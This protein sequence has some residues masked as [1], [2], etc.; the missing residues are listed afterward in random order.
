MG[1]LIVMTQATL[2]TKYLVDIFAT[3]ILL[4]VHIIELPTLTYLCFDSL[5]SQTEGY[6]RAPRCCVPR[7]LS[8]AKFLGRGPPHFWSS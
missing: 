5:H 6:V 8:T 7:Y 2:Q 1:P 4:G 3:S